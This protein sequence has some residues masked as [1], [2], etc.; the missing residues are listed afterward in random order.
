MTPSLRRQNLWEWMIRMMLSVRPSLRATALILLCVFAVLATA[1]CKRGDATARSAIETDLTNEAREVVALPG[2][3]VSKAPLLLLEEDERADVTDGAKADNSRCFVCHIN[4][5]EEPIAA[6]HA[7]HDIGC[8]HCHG[9]SDAHIADE[10]W[11]S[12]GNGTAP[13]VMYP[14]DRIN[15]ACMACHSQD[16]LSSQQ[17]EPVFRASNPKVCTD[18]HGSHRLPVRRCKWR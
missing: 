11:G 18:C 15:P 5:V 10:S 17:H 14:R 16:Q 7:R 6:N 4:Y 12:G 13:D 8:V 1:G 3:T 2:E 9:P